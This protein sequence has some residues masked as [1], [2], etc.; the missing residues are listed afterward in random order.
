MTN[1]ELQKASEALTAALKKRDQAVAA[2][3]K[4]DAEVESRKAPLLRI[5]AGK[6]EEPKTA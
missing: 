2:L 3:A 1:T 6:T 5:L 4:A